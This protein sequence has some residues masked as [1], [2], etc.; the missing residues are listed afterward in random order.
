MPPG[1]RG[2]RAKV[3]DDRGAEA[4]TGYPSRSALGAPT[5]AIWIPKHV[6]QCIRLIGDR[7][8]GI[9]TTLTFFASGARLLARGLR[10]AA[11]ILSLNKT[12]RASCRRKV[13]LPSRCAPGSDCHRFA[14]RFR[15]RSA[16]AE[17]VRCRP[18]LSIFKMTFSL[19]SRV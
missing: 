3:S 6:R 19:V 5:P 12:F 8:R 13:T 18:D 11:A 14:S 10:Q 16:F 9:A 15:R 4:P 7:S 2:R 17:G 1:A